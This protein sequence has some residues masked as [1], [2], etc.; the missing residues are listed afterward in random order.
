MAEPLLYCDESWRIELPLPVPVVPF[1]TPGLESL[2]PEAD[3]IG[4]EAP[5]PPDPA[6]PEPL[7]PAA[8]LPPAAPAPPACA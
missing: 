5:G 7:A 2:D 4:E 6:A 1:D 8:P 3:P